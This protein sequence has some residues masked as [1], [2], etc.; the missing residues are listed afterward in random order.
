[1]LFRIAA[2][3]AF[4]ASGVFLAACNST[5]SPASDKKDPNPDSDTAFKV[6]GTLVADGQSYPAHV[7][8][9]YDDTT[10]TLSI[11]ANL[12][13]LDTGWTLMVASRSAQGVQPITVK[14]TLSLNG[15]H[16][17][18]AADA[19]CPYAVKSGSAAFD[20]W[21]R[22]TV[23]RYEM[24]RMSGSVSVELTRWSLV[25]EGCPDRTVTLSFTDAEATHVR[26]A[27]GIL[28]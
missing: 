11:L 20:A 23:G 28:D 5:D 19:G 4:L 3:L 6:N 1:M 9:L 17:A 21:T 18:T 10:V 22:F 26:A 16:R 15:T 2:S 24:S 25:T 27:D 7:S 12:N 14:T 13:A 8:G